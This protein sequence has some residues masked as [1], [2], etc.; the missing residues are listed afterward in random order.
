MET[1]V[2]KFNIRKEKD[3]AFDEAYKILSTHKDYKNYFVEVAL[4]KIAE[5]KSEDDSPNENG[6]RFIFANCVNAQGGFLINEYTSL[7]RKCP[8]NHYCTNYLKP[9]PCPEGKK[10][11]PGSSSI[12]DCKQR[13]SFQHV[14][15][16]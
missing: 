10:S 1:N 2:Y 8:T 9:K 7:Y 16:M 11:P 3:G 6:H 15:L 14:C 5:I 13:K 4:S 12:E